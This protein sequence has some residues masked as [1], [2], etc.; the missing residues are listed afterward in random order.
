MASYPFGVVQGAAL[1]V[2][3]AAGVFGA[4]PAELSPS[5]PVRAFLEGNGS[6]RPLC[7]T[8]EGLA[9]WAVTQAFYAGRDHRPAWLD[10]DGRPNRA[11]RRLGEVLLHAPKD[12]LDAAQLAVI[13]TEAAAPE[14]VR[15]TVALLRYASAL[16]QGTRGPQSIPFWRP[17]RRSVD[18]AAILG[19]A[20]DDPAGALD[21]VRPWHPQHARL[22]EALARYREAAARETE[23]LV[24]PARPLLRAGQRSPLV[25]RIRARLVLEGDLA[26]GDGPAAE[27]VYDERLAAGVR[28]FEA[29]HGLPPDGRFDADLAAALSVPLAQR[30]RQIELNLERWRWSPPSGEGRGVLVNIPTFTLHAYD[31]GREALNMRVVTGQ[32]HL[33]TPVFTGDMT[34]VVFS[35]YWNVPPNIA[36]NET[37]P[38]VLRDRSYLRRMGLE[39]VRDGRVVDPAGI[40][41]AGWRSVG[42]RQRP[43]P[44]NALGLVKFLF[45]N[46]FNVYLHDT[47][48]DHLFARARRAYSHGCIRVQKPE[49]LAR[50]VL[51]G[52]AGWTPRTIGAAMRGGRERG[53]PLDQS[54]PLTIGYFTVWVNDDGAVRFLPDVYGHDAAQMGAL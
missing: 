22:A 1:S 20:L 50:W 52:H 46:P 14:D 12:G 26:A 30:V 25:A 53:V 23:A 10:P 15:A 16:G 33:P 28:R 2:L 40:T 7:D 37:L 31:D 9:V 17:V 29:R 43:G 34:T 19:R 18:L 21:S 49:E 3:L 5:A 6:P 45:P 13:S 36:S 8:P 35:P 47:P 27:D 44:G 51:D 48:E 39:A 32:P 38:A 24:V 41:R 42:F 54:I 4:P 11:G